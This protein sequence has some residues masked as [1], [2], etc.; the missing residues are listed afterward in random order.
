M[1]VLVGW[2]GLRLS[3]RTAL[4]SCPERITVSSHLV[5]KALW[6]FDND[7]TKPIRMAKLVD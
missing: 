1:S 2:Q 7:S 6:P 4:I 5:S 3:D